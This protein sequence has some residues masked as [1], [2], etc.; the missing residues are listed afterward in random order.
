VGIKEYNKKR[1]AKVLVKLERGEL[2]AVVTID[3]AK[4]HC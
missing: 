1:V 4:P 3:S 2:L